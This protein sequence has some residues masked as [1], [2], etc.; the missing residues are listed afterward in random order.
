MQISAHFWFWHFYL[1]LFTVALIFHIHKLT[2]PSASSFAKSNGS[3]VIQ[4]LHNLKLYL[5]SE[6]FTYKHKILINEGRNKLKL[7]LRPCIMPWRLTRGCGSKV[8][9]ILDLSTRWTWVFNFMLQLLY[10]KEKVTII[11]LKRLNGPTT[12]LDVTTHYS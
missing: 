8:P 10:L 1:H 6:N 3:L 12:C 4:Y 5:I 9:R 2:F 11:I 7:S